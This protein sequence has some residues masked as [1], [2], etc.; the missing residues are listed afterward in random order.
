A[1]PG[2]REVVGE[3]RLTVDA[4]ELRQDSV[5]LV[6]E[7]YRRHARELRPATGPRT[8][9]PRG[10]RAYT[11][12]REAA[13]LRPASGYRRGAAVKCRRASTIRRRAAATPARRLPCL[14]SRSEERRVGKELKNI[15]S[16]Y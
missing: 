11:S 2:R 7:Q 16:R 3:A 5:R 1:H 15:D 4:R 14:S 9:R 13:W 6:E 10:P 8:R 12:A